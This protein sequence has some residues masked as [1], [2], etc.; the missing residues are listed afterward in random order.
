MS[1]ELSQS[2]Q[3]DASVYQLLCDLVEKAAG[4]E[5]NSEDY[6]AIGLCSKAIVLDMETATRDIVR[7]LGADIEASV[8]FALAGGYLEAQEAL[9][10][11]ENATS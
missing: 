5:L 6:S 8:E 4:R 9:E 1:I 11:T 3:L 7:E 10:A 2:E